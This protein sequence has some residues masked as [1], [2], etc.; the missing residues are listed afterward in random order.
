[1]K[2]CPGCEREIDKYAIACQYCGKLS[3]LQK[4]ARG[5]D[6]PP[7]PPKKDGKNK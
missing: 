7:S 2:K 5:P 6:R 4:Q 3:S 1:M